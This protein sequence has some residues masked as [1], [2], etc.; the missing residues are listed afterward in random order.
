M[1][2]DDSTE[3]VSQLNHIGNLTNE[4][5]QLQLGTEATCGG[6][7]SHPCNVF[8]VQLPKPFS[9]IVTSVESLTA[10]DKTGGE[11]W[12]ANGNLTG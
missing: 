5:V 11:K 3:R 7:L 8:L 1:C 12:R 2:E 4:G 6:Y 10:G 9:N